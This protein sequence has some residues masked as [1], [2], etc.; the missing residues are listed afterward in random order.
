MRAG[1]RDAVLAAVL[2]PCTGPGV[3]IPFEMKHPDS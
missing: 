3:D 1:R 2:H